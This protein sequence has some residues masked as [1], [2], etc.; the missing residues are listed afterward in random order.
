MVT[1]MHFTRWEGNR[2]VRHKCILPPPN[3]PWP[4]TLDTGSAARDFAGTVGLAAAISLALF[5]MALVWF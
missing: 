1:R 5:A 2:L 3:Q 4:K